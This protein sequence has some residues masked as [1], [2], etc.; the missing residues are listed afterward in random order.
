MFAFDN[1]SYIACSDDR[2]DG[3]IDLHVLDECGGDGS[4][5]KSDDS[6][7]IGHLFYQGYDGGRMF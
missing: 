6:L 3:R 2:F 1:R 5:G 4:A 7:C